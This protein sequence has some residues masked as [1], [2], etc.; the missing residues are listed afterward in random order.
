MNLSVISEDDIIKGIKLSKPS[1]FKW[2]KNKYYPMIRQL[3]LMNNGTEEDAEDIFQTGVIVLWEKIKNDSFERK[4]SVKTFFYSV[5]R[6]Q[7]RK[8][9]NEKKGFMV[10]I[11]DIITPIDLP[12][13]E[14]D[15]AD[16]HNYQ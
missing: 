2:I 8:K 4:S 12:Q 13:P 3:V 1:V 16:N 6:N 5:C 10:R 15:D 11:D 14:S 7:W 9:L